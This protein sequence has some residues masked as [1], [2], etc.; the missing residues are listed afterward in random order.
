MKIML[1]SSDTKSLIDFRG[2]LMIQMKEKGHEII[3]VAPENEF[4]EEFNK[5][6]VRFEQLK[7]NRASTSILGDISFYFKVKLL[8]KSEKPDMVFSYALKPVIYGSISAKK[9]GVNK[10]YSL[11]P[12]LGHAFN[13]D[14]LSFKDRLVNK[15]VKLLLRYAC[16]YNKRVIVQNPDDKEEL[17]N[18]GIVSEYKIERVNSSGVNMDKFK[19]TEYPENITFIMISRLLKNKGV[20]EYISAAKNIKKEYKKVKFLLVGPLDSNPLSLSKI[21]LEN[22]IADGCVEYLGVTNDVREYISRSSVFVLP[23]YYREGVPRSTQEAMAMGRPIITTDWIGCRETVIDKYNGYLIQAKNTN[24][25]EEAMRNFI[26]DPYLIKNMGENSI[27]Y[28]KEKFEVNII[29]E[30][31]IKYIDLS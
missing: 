30:Q 29:N 8:I 17:I 22:L 21:E 2:D 6:G 10:I 11:L 25:L 26:K 9:C 7:F 15:I 1:I 14:N 19:P 13:R 5:M 4:L 12:G 31:M 3:A 20:L 27:K 23:S 16:K 24:Q 28:C 18:E